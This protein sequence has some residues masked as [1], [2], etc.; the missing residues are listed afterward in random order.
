MLAEAMEVEVEVEV[1]VEEY[2][3]RFPA[4]RDEE[5]GKRLVGSERTP[6]RARVDYRGRQDSDSATS[7]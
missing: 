3:N 7:G 6:S 4:L 2:I 5:R 1:E